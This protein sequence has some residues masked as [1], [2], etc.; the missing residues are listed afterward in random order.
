MCG[1]WLAEDIVSVLGLF[2]Y[3][4]AMYS[5]IR[6]RKCKKEMYFVMEI[7]KEDQSSALISA[8][9]PGESGHPRQ[10]SQEVI[11]TIHFHAETSAYQPKLLSASRPSHRTSYALP[12]TRPHHTSFH[13]SYHD[14]HTHTMVKSNQPLQIRLTEPV[15]FLKGPSTGLDFRGRPQAV[16]QDGQPAMV[17]GLLTLRLNKPTRIRS[18]TIKLEGKARTEWPEGKAPIFGAYH[19]DTH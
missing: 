7:R 19:V 8:V 3:L 15:I 13:D 18:I 17:R 2:D 14:N 4:Y 5:L 6:K 9:N 16:R 10:S 12:L 11:I 1:M